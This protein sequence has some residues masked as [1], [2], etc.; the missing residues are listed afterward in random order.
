M[1]LQPESRARGAEARRRLRSAPS[2]QQLA[3]TRLLTCTQG[4][5]RSRLWRSRA[6]TRRRAACS[7]DFTFVCPTEIIAFSNA[8]ASFHELNA[9]VLAISTDS[10]HT[11]LAWKKTERE[12]GGL[13][14]VK[15]PLVADTSKDISRSYGVLVEDKDDDMYG[16]ALR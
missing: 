14:D 10:H 15:I 9:E 13:G 8:V 16:A 12:A 2:V 7:F 11:H 6:L 5:V 1:A 3:S 4:D